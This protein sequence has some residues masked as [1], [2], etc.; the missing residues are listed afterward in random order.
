MQ[1][2][3]D[4]ECLGNIEPTSDDLADGM[5]LGLGDEALGCIALPLE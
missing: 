2:T 1:Y 5:S 3:L 4:G